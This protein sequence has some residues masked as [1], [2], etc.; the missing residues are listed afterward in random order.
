MPQKVDDNSEEKAVQQVV[1]ILTEAIRMNASDIHFEPYE[2]CFRIRIR[3][4]G[5]LHSLTELPL[6]VAPQ[7]L[8]RLKI[9]GKLDI[10]ER[11]L[12]QDGRFS[13]D[14]NSQMKDCRIS[15]CP[16]LHG[17]KIVVRLLD[18]N[19][20][21]L[22]IDEL[23]LEEKQKT[24]FMTHIKK[25]QGMILVTGPTGSGKTFTLYTALNILNAMEKNISTVEDPVEIQ[26]SG[27]NQVNVNSKINLTFSAALRSFLR[28]DPDI[29]M[30]GE[31]RDTETAEI[32]IKAAQTGHLVFSTLHTNSAVETLVRL[33]NMGMTAYNIAHSV[34]LIVAQRLLRKSC[35]C[36]MGC[37]NCVKGYRGR[38][39]VFEC[40][41]VTE[42][43]SKAMLSGK[44]V[45]EITNI[46]KQTGMVTLYE[47]ALNK[48]ASGITNLSEVQRVIVN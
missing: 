30:V 23:G 33:I 2:N 29:I 7:I 15:T 37:K 41:P 25:P 1:Q 12:P 3:V 21:T 39:G 42:D 22:D 26:L 5:I 19:K 35:E 4:D 6:T 32:A 44:T 28:Q 9:L 18:G 13:F 11:R 36:E 40:L 27:I 46:A 10:A 14:M 24:L 47:A 34:S 43:I 31:I 38:I 8:A 45:H 48:V 20:N 16:V 17:E